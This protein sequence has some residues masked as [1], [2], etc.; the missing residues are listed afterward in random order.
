MSLFPTRES[1]SG[2]SGSGAPLQPARDVARAVGRV[3]GREGKF[4]E[5]VLCP[6]SDSGL[7][8]GMHPLR[9]ENGHDVHDRI[10]LEKS[11]DR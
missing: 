1:E 4:A 5:P 7:P 10:C 6:S 8:A 3:R 11:H 2:V 9:E